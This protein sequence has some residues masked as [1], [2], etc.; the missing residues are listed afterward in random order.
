MAEDT[1]LVGDATTG[2]V[3]EVPLTEE[4]HAQRAADAAASGKQQAASAFAVQEDDER[5]A[6][7]NDRAATDPAYAALADFVLRGRQT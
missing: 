7:I 2:E 5:L 3:V 6:V 1:K 4:E